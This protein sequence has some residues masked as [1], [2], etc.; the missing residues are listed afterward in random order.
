MNHQ[1]R[2][3]TWGRSS[4]VRIPK[5]VLQEAGIDDPK[6]VNVA[7]T[8]RGNEIVLTPHIQ[9]SPFEQLFKGRPSQSPPAP[10]LWETDDE[11]VGKEVL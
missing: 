1:T 3:G 10:S 4:A 8:V 6:E 7:I 11:P 9:L 2:F 5:S